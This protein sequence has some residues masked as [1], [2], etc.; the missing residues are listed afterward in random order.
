MKNILGSTIVLVSA[1]MLVAAC[2]GDSNT[3]SKQNDQRSA[4]SAALQ[5]TW[6]SN[7]ESSMIT[8]L[9]Y[10]DTTLDTERVYFFDKECQERA[11]TV[12][13][14]GALTLANNYKEGQNNSI[15]F[16]PAN[17]V[18]ATFHTLYQVDTTNNVLISFR[19]D[20]K[21]STID[22]KATPAERSRIVRENA[23]IKALLTL[24]DFKLDEEK[25]LTSL[26]LE[27]LQNLGV[28]EVQEV[29]E[30]GSR[31]ALRYEF[32]NNNLQVGGLSKSSMVFVRK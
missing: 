6:V 7:C 27:K 19:K 13:H 11:M 23:K 21:E 22:P 2:G 3:L 4:V 9:K 15:I 16:V 25:T 1:L 12:R 32:D 17:E 8:T 24:V 31:N 14:Q 10:T 28:S 5:G 20:A 26:Q 18:R 29:A 30:F